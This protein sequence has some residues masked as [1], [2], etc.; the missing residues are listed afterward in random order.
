[1]LIECRGMVVFGIDNERKGTDIALEDTE[2]GIGYQS[3][4]ETFAAEAL[5][6]GKTAASAAGTGG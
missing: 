3:T 4:A 2:S 5:V 6:N 1:M